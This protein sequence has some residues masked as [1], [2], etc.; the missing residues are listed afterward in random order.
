MN[1][2]ER[3]VSCFKTG[4]SCSQALLST[5]GTQFGLTRETALKVSGAFG[6]GV[7]RRGET[8]GAVTGAFMLIGLKH[9]MTIVDDEVAKEETY[10]LV[11]EFV[12]RFC[13]KS[14]SVV[15]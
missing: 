10:R 2:V 11:N 7:S 8:C 14:C 9:G 15:I 6:S 13:V 12:A 1:R 5:Y 3:A 4:F